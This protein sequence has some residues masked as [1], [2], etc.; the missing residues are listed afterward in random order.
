MTAFGEL[1]GKANKAGDTFTGDITIERDNLNNDVDLAVSNTAT[2]GTSSVI[3]R[4]N[5]NTLTSRLYMDQTGLVKLDNNGVTT[6]QVYP[7]GVLATPRLLQKKLF[8][9]FDNGTADNPSSATNFFGFGIETGALRYQTPVTTTFHRF[10]CGT[11]QVLEVGGSS[12]TFATDLNITN[13]TDST[14]RL[15]IDCPASGGTSFLTM[16]SRNLAT[17]EIS[18]T[19]STWMYSP[20]TSNVGQLFRTTAN[21]STFVNAISIS[22]ST[23]AVTMGVSP[24][25]VVSTPYTSDIRLKENIQDINVDDCLHIFNNLQIKTFDWKRDGKPSLGVIAQ[26][27]ESLLP[28]NN[29][30]DIVHE[31]EYQPTSDDEP[32]IVKTVDYTRLN[33]LLYVVVKEQQ[34][35]ID[36]L[37][38]RLANIENLLSGSMNI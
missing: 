33:T 20:L 1:S 34:K 21:G 27:V 31:C 32:M 4:T 18:L 3:F 23:G 7:N 15:T 35:R 25:T 29:K 16:K 36:A 17:A 14:K 11:T 37:E 8:V 2:T 9:L 12:S 24:L 38:T 5:N 26:E 28:T 30:F 6:F 13:T 22:G 10:F 19:N